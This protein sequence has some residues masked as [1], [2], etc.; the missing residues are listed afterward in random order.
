MIG[1]DKKG[2]D[3][4]HCG[5]VHNF[6]ITEKKTFLRSRTWADSTPFFVSSTLKII[7]MLDKTCRTWYIDVCGP[8]HCK[9]HHDTVTSVI[10]PIRGTSTRRIKTDGG[11]EMAIRWGASCR[12]S[13]LVLHMFVCNCH[14]CLIKKILHI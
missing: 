8:H 3:P 5:M 13:L 9:L 10:T 7:P 2:L 1:S 11:R 4:Q 14:V 6:H 12:I